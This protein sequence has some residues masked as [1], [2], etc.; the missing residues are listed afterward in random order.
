MLDV[1]WSMNII[2]VLQNDF[3]ALAFGVVDEPSSERILYIPFSSVEISMG[4]KEIFRS[5]SDEIDCLSFLD[6]LTDPE[7]CFVSQRPRSAFIISLS[8][9]EESITTLVQIKQ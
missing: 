1:V 3:N 8:F 7:Y 5:S 6:L 4:Q 2:I 9:E